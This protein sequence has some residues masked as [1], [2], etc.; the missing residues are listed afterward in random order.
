MS[1]IQG[2]IAH[3]QIIPDAP[4]G[5]PDGTR[6]TILIPEETSNGEVSEQIGLREEDWPTTPEGIAKLV[7]RINSFEPVELTA[8]E[9]ADLLR[10]RTEMKRKSIEAM[11]QTWETAE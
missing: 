1:P 4:L 7:E 3:G 2:T 8:D 10:F 5:Q 11:K 9:E 6:V